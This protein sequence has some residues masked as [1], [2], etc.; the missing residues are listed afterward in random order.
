MLKLLTDFT[1]ACI[2]LILV[3]PVLIISMLLILFMDWQN[4]VFIQQRL[5]K[6]KRL[7]PIIKLRTMKNNQVTAL[8]K[9]LRRTGI[10][11]LPQLLNILFFQMSFVGPRPITPFDAERLGWN[12][13]YHEKRWKIRPGLTGLAQLS[14][15]CNKKMSW[16]LDQKYVTCQ[17][18]LLDLKILFSSVAVLVVGKKKVIHWMNANRNHAGT[19]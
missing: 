5:G 7:F 9:I 8:G 4:P 1:G 2:G 13:T 17:G 14:P 12:G 6:F 11:E 16:F 18:F 15:A 3:S 10:D 19:R